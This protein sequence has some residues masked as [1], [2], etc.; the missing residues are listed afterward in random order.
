[1][2]DL[3]MAAKV[4]LQIP[5]ADPDLV[6]GPAFLYTPTSGGASS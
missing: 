2:F 5:L 1:M 3:R 6:A 4:A